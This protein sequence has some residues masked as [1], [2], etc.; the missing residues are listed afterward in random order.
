MV[1]TP[2]AAHMVF[3]RSLV[4]GAHERVTIEVVGEQAGLLSADGRASL[5]LPVGSRVQIGAA[6]RPARFVRR[7]D[8]PEFLELV[9][10]KFGLPGRDG[11]PEVPG[12]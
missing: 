3:D 5:E 12:A 8:A 6:P 11:R 2:I 10:S 9:R 1:V 7:D 4:V